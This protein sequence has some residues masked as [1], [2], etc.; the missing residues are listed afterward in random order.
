MNKIER[1]D[2]YIISRHSN[3]TEE[4]IAEVLKGDIFN[5]RSAW[6]KFLRLF[7]MVL[8]IGFTVAGIVFFFAYI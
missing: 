5:D 4:E 8:G 7:F 3:L 6:E 2:I 1:E